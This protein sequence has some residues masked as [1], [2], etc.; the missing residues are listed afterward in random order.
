[1]SDIEDR[2]NHIV[3][4]IQT[5]RDDAELVGKFK[6]DIATVKKIYGLYAQATRGDVTGKKPGRLHMIARQKYEAWEQNKGM[7]RDDAM[8]EYVAI[9]EAQ[10]EKAGVEI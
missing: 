4:R 7:S 9:C 8:R 10:A 2:F 5:G 1:M 6:P 3:G